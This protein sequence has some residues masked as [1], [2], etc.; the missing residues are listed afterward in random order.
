MGMTMRAVDQP[1]RSRREY[2]QHALG[3][4][5][6][7]LE[8]DKVADEP[9]AGDEMRIGDVGPLRVVSVSAP[10]LHATTR[11]ATH[12]RRSDLDVCKI[13]VVV[14]GCGLIEQDGREARIE[15]GELVFV[16]LS[17]PVHWT[18]RDTTSMAVVFPR[19]LLPLPPA[20]VAELTA[21]TIPADRGPGALVSTVARNLAKHLDDYQG[22]HGFHVGTAVLDLLAAALATRLDRPEVV[23]PGTHQRVLLQRI[24]SFIEERLGDPDLSPGYIAAA[25]HISVRYLHKLFETEQATVAGWIRQRRLEQCRRDLLNPALRDRPAGAI[26]MRAGFTSPTHFTR[27]FRAAYGAPPAEYRAL[28]TMEGTGVSDRLP[29]GEP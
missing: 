26:G 16:D 11:A 13:D 5:I 15:Q 27:A 22:P 9:G 1:K 29:H 18:M 20:E 21:V 19:A 7:P 10:G 24:Y 6:T 8:L 4:T 17:R 3:D 14:R 25:H 12:I 2:W 23:P 28:A